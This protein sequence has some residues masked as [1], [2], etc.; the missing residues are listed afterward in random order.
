MSF[1]INYFRQVQRD[2]FT[3]NSATAKPFPKHILGPSANVNKCLCPCISLACRGMPSSRI[4]R[5]GWNCFASGPHN[6]LERLMDAM[7]AVTTVPRGI[8]R[9]VTGFGENGM[10]IGLLRGITSSS[11]AY[12]KG[13]GGVVLGKNRQEHT[14]RDDSPSRTC[15]RNVSCTTASRYGSPCVSCSHVGSPSICESSSRSLF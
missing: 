12:S 8:E 2:Q 11:V 1:I 4:H 13:S 3:L 15:K 10:R 5:D 6:A 14:I 9:R 7:G